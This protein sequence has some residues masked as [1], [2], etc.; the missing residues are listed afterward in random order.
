MLGGIN[1][2]YEWGSLPRCLQGK[3]VAARLSDPASIVQSH[4]TAG[5]SSQNV[6]SFFSFFFL[7]L[8]FLNHS[9]SE[10]HVTAK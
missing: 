6:F 1:V 10:Q 4:L 3:P 7:H 5:E 8:I 2:I 9:L